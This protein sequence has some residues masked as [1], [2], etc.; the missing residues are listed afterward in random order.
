[1]KNIFLFI[2]CFTLLFSCQK[3]EVIKSAPI[4]EKVYI[5]DPLVYE[6]INAVL[7]MPEI[8][9]H[10]PD[11]MINCSFILDFAIDED[12]KTFYTLTEKHFGEKDTI[13]IYTQIEKSKVS[14]YSEGKI[15][16]VKMIDYDLTKISKRDQL[17]SLNESIKKYR[18]Y[19]SI[20]YPIF[21]K[22]KNVA[23]MSY[24]DDSSVKYFFVEKTD[25]KWKI[26]DV[27]SEIIVCY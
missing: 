27:Y 5:T 23:H 2:S 26:I 17:D 8:S 14:Y 22:Q 4:I 16:N 10:R 1:M 18:P 3:K 6:V 21:N 13:N 15:N 25:D 24:S 11:Y 9:E 20:S 7:E 12:K 19:C